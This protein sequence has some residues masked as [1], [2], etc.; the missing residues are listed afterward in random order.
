MKVLFIGGERSDAQAVATALRSLD[1]GV[2]VSWAARV[3]HS[4]RWLDQN[5]DLSAIVVGGQTDERRLSPLF[6]QL[7]AL[8]LHPAIVVIVAD[9]APLDSLPAGAGL[10]IPRNRFLYRDLPVV[11]TRACERAARV[12]LELKLATA[13]KLAAEQRARLQEREFELN[14]LLDAATA[15]RKV[16]EDRLTA[17]ASALE[18]AVARTDQERAD[19]ATLEGRLA[20]V[21]DV[22]R[23]AASRGAELA[24]RL[25]QEYLLRSSLD[26]ALVEQRRQF[27][28]QLAQAQ[29]D[30][31]NMA[32]TCRTLLG[33]VQRAREWLT[34]AMPDDSRRQGEYLFDE[35]SHDV[36]VLEELAAGSDDH[37]QPPLGDAEKEP[38]HVLANVRHVSGF[39]RT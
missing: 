38:S 9:G 22:L 1:Q 15:S 31:S 13:E 37:L 35:I 18:D 17:A 30:R 28:A 5:R 16:L 7:Q 19:R 39:S 6:E 12:A 20:D 14:T 34:G 3:E 36:S 33:S 23:E 4:R 26:T 27:D 25:E 21:G 10:G 32:A 29:V 24:E 11:V 2:T 8:G